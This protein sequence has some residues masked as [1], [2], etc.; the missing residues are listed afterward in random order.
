MAETID[1]DATARRMAELTDP[2]RI[3]EQLVLVWNAGGA[4]DMATIEM[5]LS[6]TMGAT[7]AGPD[8]KNLDRAVR[9][10]NR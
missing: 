8:L 4:A 2:E 5:T 1:F 9:G 10:L 6:T 7:A 3:R